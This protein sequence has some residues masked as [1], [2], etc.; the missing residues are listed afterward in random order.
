[1]GLVG[2]LVAMGGAQPDADRPGDPWTAICAKGVG[3]YERRQ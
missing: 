2:H 1:M 3:G